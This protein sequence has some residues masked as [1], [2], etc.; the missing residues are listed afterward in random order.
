MMCS[1][2][3]G[4]PLLLLPLAHPPYSS[5]QHAL[6]SPPSCLPSLLIL[7]ARPYSPPSCPPSLLISISRPYYPSSLPAL[8]TR[9]PAHPPNQFPIN[10]VLRFKLSLTQNYFICKYSL[11]CKHVSLFHSILAFYFQSFFKS[12]ILFPSKQK[13]FYSMFTML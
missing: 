10:F 9:P 12:I 5:S 8:P 7:L 2:C 3:S 4:S 11:M 6:S 1:G 13:I